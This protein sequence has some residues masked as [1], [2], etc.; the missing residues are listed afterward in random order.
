MRA[1]RQQQDH[2]LRLLGIQNKLAEQDRQMRAFMAHQEQFM[3]TLQPPIMEQSQQLRQLQANQAYLV[4]A[5]G[6]LNLAM[7]VDFSQSSSDYPVPGFASPMPGGH[8]GGHAKGP[9]GSSSQAHPSQSGEAMM[10]L[11]PSSVCLCVQVNR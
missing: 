10:Q 5:L 2:I 4:Q 9:G 6:S 3:R 7:P 11:V 1:L 8:G